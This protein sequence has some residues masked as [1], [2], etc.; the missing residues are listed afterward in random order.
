[1]LLVNNVSDVLTKA[2]DRKTFANIT[3]QWGFVD[4]TLSEMH[5]NP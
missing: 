3:S 2:M 5:K 1:M 4:V